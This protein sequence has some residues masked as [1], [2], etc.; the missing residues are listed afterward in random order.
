[1][2]NEVFFDENDNIKIRLVGFD[3]LFPIQEVP[4]IGQRLGISYMRSQQEELSISFGPEKL[5]LQQS[6]SGPM[7]ISSVVWDAGLILVDFL[8]S[9]NHSNSSMFRNICEKSSQLGHVLDLGCGTGIGGIAC[10]TT[11]CNSVTFTD[12]FLSNILKE[13]MDSL[14]STIPKTFVAY[15]WEE[16]S[17]PI[18]LLHPTNNEYEIWDTIICSDVLYDSK[19]HSSL[20]NVLKTIR[21]SKLI[22]SYKKRHDEHEKK[23]FEE[24]NIWCDLYIVNKDLIPLVN[25]PLNALSNLYVII[26]IPKAQ[27]DEQTS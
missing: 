10:V 17:M 2:L 21:F 7:A 20:M 26:A 14:S 13:N 4:D 16:K 24:L 9:S 18:S 25:L 3:L 1:M 5:I 6:S 15:N 22:I 8:Y 27:M 23:F 11:G 12:T 19:Y